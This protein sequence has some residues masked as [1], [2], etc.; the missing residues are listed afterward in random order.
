VYGAK[1]RGS[2][3]W[4][5]FH[6]NMTQAARERL[7]L[8]ARLRRALELGHMRLY[9]QPQID[10]ATG[11]VV[12]AEALLRWLDPEEGLI[13]PARFIPVAE[14]SGVIGPLGL[15]VLGEACRQG[16]QWRAAGLP[17]LTIAVNVSLHQFLLTDIAG[18]TADALN[19]SGFPASLL[20]LEITESALA[21]KPEE[22]LAVLNRLRELGL[23]LAIDDFGTG[24]SSLSYLKKFDIDYLKID[25]SFVRMLGTD[26]NDRALCEAIIVMAHKLGLGVIAEGVE[27]ES[28]F[29]VLKDL[30]CDI[31][32]GYYF[33]RPLQADGFVKLLTN[34]EVTH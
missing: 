21:E 8:E 1:A 14:N 31:V 6:E 7:A 3:A 23:R 17:D 16:Q 19:K 18:A 13:S 15:W 26:N 9:Y 33:H 20:E 30:G 12:G 4:C 29:N 24:Y 11:R 2:N 10:L 32:Q 22:A 25:Q 27:T 34:I 5:F 28:Q